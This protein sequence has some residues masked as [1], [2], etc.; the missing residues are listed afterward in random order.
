[1]L[2]VANDSKYTG[3]GRN[4]IQKNV[5]DRSTPAEWKGDEGK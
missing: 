2:L 1:M 5:T 3:A 4:P